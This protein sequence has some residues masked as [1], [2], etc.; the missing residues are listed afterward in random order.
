MPKT[1]AGLLMYKVNDG[2]LKVFLVHPGGPFWKNKD[3]GAWSIPKGE[4]EE[5]E[6]ILET[7]RR[8]FEE[9]IGIKPKEELVPLG[10]IKQKSGKIVHTWA[11]EGEWPG[12]LLKQNIIEIDFHGEKIKIPEID[13]AGFFP[14][15]TAREKIIPAQ[16]EFIDRL[17]K[18]FNN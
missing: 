11:F 4:V 16:K 12:M 3:I 10:K 8:E 6:D 9:E 15:D 18:F 13:K 2:K 7:A 14:V 17:E 5:N 1:S